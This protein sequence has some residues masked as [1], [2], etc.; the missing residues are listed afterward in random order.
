MESPQVT[1]RPGGMLQR[2][3]FSRASAR[4]RYRERHRDA[5]Q[6]GAIV[7]SATPDTGAWCSRRRAT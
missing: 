6:H 7:S 4:D 3:G 1:R 5:S 2:E